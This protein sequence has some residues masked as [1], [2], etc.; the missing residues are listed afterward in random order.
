[1]IIKAACVMLDS[2]IYIHCD[3]ALCGMLPLCKLMAVKQCS[4]RPDAF[5]KGFIKCDMCQH[6]PFATSNT[7]T[8][9]LV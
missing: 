7:F 4:A 1:M 3:L 6:E 9:V 5:L 8:L 2:G